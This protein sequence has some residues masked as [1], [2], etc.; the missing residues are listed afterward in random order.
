MCDEMSRGGAREPVRESWG[1]RPSADARYLLV[2][3]AR[4]QMYT[5]LYQ[6]KA[7][8]NQK[9]ETADKCPWVPVG[10]L[11]EPLCQLSCCSCCAAQC[12][13]ARPVPVFFSSVRGPELH[14]CVGGRVFQPTRVES[15][16]CAPEWV[17]AH[18]SI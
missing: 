7:P 14:L 4:L 2:G 13:P 10:E 17:C 5:I 18:S 1:D 12:G 15:C 8:V 6:R 16:V 3:P 11:A 9:C